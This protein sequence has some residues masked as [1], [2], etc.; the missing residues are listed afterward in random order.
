MTDKGMSFSFSYTTQ[1]KTYK[2]LQ[3]LDK[4]KTCQENGIPAKM[5]KS[6]NDIFSYFIHHNFINSLFSSIFP[7]ELKKADIIPIPKTKSKFDIESYCP[8]SILP[9]LYKIF[10]RCMF[11][12]IYSYS[13]QILFKHQCGFQQSHST[14]NSLL[15]MVEKLKK[16]WTIVV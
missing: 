7:S 4:K 12:Q 10:E 11:N 8:V 1:K 6:N 5:I 2:T 3:N 13:N 14:Q 16:V 9:V 15:L